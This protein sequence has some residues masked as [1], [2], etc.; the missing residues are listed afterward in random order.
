MCSWDFSLSAGA[1]AWE[2]FWRP[3][4]EAGWHDVFALAKRGE[5][6]IEGNLQPLMANLQYVKDMAALG[7][8]AA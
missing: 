4:P 3:F 1:P 7:R 2:R 8:E 6:A 5:M